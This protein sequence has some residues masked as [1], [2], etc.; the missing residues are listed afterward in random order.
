MESLKYLKLITDMKAKTEVRLED[1]AKGDF[2]LCIDNSDNGTVMICVNDLNSDEN[3][4]WVT[5]NVSVINAL[6]FI[7]G[8]Q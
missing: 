4:Y 2:K 1:L 5:V 8:K 7:K 6:H 3:S